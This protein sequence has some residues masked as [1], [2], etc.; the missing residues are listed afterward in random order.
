ME[1]GCPHD[2]W[3]RLTSASLIG[4]LGSSAFQTNHYLGVDVARGLAIRNSDDPF[5][6]MPARLPEAPA[7][8]KPAPARRS[9]KEPANLRRLIGGQQLAG[10]D[11]K[12]VVSEYS[13][14]S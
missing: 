5:A 8:E 12:L 1:R 11:R 4:R 6:L 14:S 3:H 10:C 7:E 13:G 2:D 9:L